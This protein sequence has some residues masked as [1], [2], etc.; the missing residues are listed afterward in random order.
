M[1]EL[2]LD[3]SNQL[4]KKGLLLLKPR[5][6]RNFGQLLDIISYQKTWEGEKKKSPPFHSSHVHSRVMRDEQGW[7]SSGFRSREGKEV[8]RE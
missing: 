5:T 1:Q 3:A 8:R 2:H 6:E 4:K 7:G